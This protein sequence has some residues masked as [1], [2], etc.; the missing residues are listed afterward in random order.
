MRGRAVDD[1]RHRIAPEEI[2]CE[3]DAG[4]G[5]E[6][7]GIA[8]CMAWK[9]ANLNFPFA[10]IQIDSIDIQN[11]RPGCIGRCEAIDHRDT[12]VANDKA[13]VCRGHTLRRGIV[14]RGP[15]IRADLFQRER[16]NGCA[17]RLSDG[18]HPEQSARSHNGEESAY[19]GSH[20]HLDTVGGVL[21][22]GTDKRPRS[23]GRL[24]QFRQ[25]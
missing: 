19:G 12:V 13:A 5:Y 3:R 21:V 22:R 8:T 14:D 17:L 6:H 1:V 15:H 4:V 10:E 7:N 25:R 16:G 18:R 11:R 9:K 2:P 23:S 24:S 20:A